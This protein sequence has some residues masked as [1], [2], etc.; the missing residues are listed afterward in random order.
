MTRIATVMLTK[1]VGKPLDYLVPDE[2][3]DTLKVGAW[4]EVPLRQG[5]AQG[6]VIALRDAAPTHPLKPIGKILLKSVSMASDLLK[7]ADWMEEYYAAPKSQVLKT[8]LPASIRQGKGKKETSSS[9][10][11]NEEYFLS[12]A[13]PLSV[14]QKSAFEKIVVSLNEGKY[15]THLLFGITGSGKTEVYLQALEHTLKLGKSALILV[16]EVALTAQ[17]IERFK[18]RF[19]EPMAVL[20]HRLTPKQKRE[21]WEQLG[22]GKIKL[23]IGAR[24]AVFS[25]L[26]NLGLIIVDEEHDPSYKESERSPTYHARDVA[27]FR[28]LLNQA[29]V[30]LGSAT[31]SLESYH[32]SLTGKYILSKLSERPGEA[33]LPEVKIVDMNREVERKKGFT[34]FSEELLSGIEKRHERGEQTLLFLN[35][36]GYH[37]EL[38]CKACGKSISCPQ[39]DVPLTFHKKNNHLICHLCEHEVS[40]PPRSCPSC[41]ASEPLKFKGTGTEQVEASLRA[42]FPE[43]RVLRID[44]DSTKTAGSHQ[45]L[46]KSFKTGKAE[47]LVGTQMIAKG[48]HFPEV[49]LVGILSGDTAL[50]IPDFRAGETTFQLLTQVAGRAG[51]GFTPGEVVIQTFLPAHNVIQHA[52]RHDYEAFF[53]EEMES[54]QLFGFPPFAKLCKVRFASTDL[55]ALQAYASSF[56]EKLKNSLP[57]DYNLSDAAPSGHPKIKSVHRMQ[58]VIRGA[59][60]APMTRA[61]QQ[62]LKTLPPPGSVRFLID[63]DPVSVFY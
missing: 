11:E 55:P 36:R 63:V 46:F 51:R 47:V 50:Q 9:P 20:H 37:R 41:E 32:N 22:A 45:Q 49:T 39:C 26:Q 13:K 30:V 10:L 16:P 59:K 21:A 3:V 33:Q 60:T 48:L 38:G 1:N 31:P 61:I 58:C 56:C 6:S 4:V 17:T 25:P 15:A 5:H 44:A 52:A 53:K 24:S 34:L 35:R 7:L 8:M 28:G 12:P 29:T 2:M 62:L 27:V 43:V 23:A 57:S 42:I 54:R 14:D 19:N 40:P 18:S